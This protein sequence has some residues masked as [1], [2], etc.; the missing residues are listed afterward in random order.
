LKKIIRRFRLE[1]AMDF[2]FL[3]FFWWTWGYCRDYRKPKMCWGSLL[4]QYFLFLFDES[5]THMVF[6]DLYCL[7]SPE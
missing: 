6:N 2:I 4:K 3:L 1:E 7:T 5:L